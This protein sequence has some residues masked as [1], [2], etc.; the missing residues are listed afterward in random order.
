M[1]SKKTKFLEEELANEQCNLARNAWHL[2]RFVIEHDHELKLPDD[3]EPGQFMIWAEKYPKL[4]DS[5]RIAFVDQYASLEKI[6][7]NVTARTLFATR[8]HGEGFIHAAFHTS[9]GIYLVFLA[10]ITAI[11]FTL[12]GADIAVDGLVAK[13]LGDNLSKSVSPNILTPFCAAGLGTS[14]YL[15]R[16]TQEKL[17]SREFDPAHIPSQLIRLGLGVLAGGS[18]VLFPDLFVFGMTSGPAGA[19]EAVEAINGSNQV[20]VQKITIG[21]A[22]LAFV[23]GYAVEIFYSVLDNIGGR[24]KDHAKK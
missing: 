9:V 24:I 16:V 11:F 15:L 4:D 22:T 18:I 10:V 12:L 5:E 14:V 3:F 21:Q 13:I 23:F 7:K 6:S 19:K 17:L 1:D 8:I 20:T 2:S